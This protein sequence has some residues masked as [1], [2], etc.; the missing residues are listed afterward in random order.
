MG[1]EHF[2]RLGAEHRT[3]VTAHLTALDKNS[4]A[5][6]FGTAARNESIAKYGAAI[7]FERDIVEGVWDDE[8]L[9]GVAHLAVYPDGGHQVGEL[10][11]SVLPE[12]RHQH[13][14]QRLLSR[15]LLFARMKRLKRVNVYFLVR[16]GPM[17]RLAREFTSIV[18]TSRGEAHAVIDME[19]LAPVAM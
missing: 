17:A 13:L 11:I 9:V 10:G 2:L 8:T 18:K 1:I 14:G 3:A 16:N 6:R 4:R 5:L 15:V 12:A 7:D 19:E